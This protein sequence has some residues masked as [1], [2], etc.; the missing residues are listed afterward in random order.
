MRIRE[1]YQDEDNFYFNDGFKTI[2]ISK[3]V[4]FPSIGTDISDWSFL[5]RLKPATKEEYEEQYRA[6]RVAN[7]LNILKTSESYKLT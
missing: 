4:L 3:G 6:V 5:S 7:D 2:S 1:Y